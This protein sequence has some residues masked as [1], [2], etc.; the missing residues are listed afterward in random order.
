[1]KNI[2]HSASL[3][4]SPQR[5]HPAG[6]RS[7]LALALLCAWG[8]AA[9]ADEAATQI[10]VTGSVV[11][12]R[13]D[14]VPYAA[15]VVGQDALRTAGPMINL[16]E[17]LA[18]VPGLVVNLRNNYAQDLQ[19]SSRGFGSRAGFGVRGLRLYADGIPAT[20]PDGQGQVSHFDLAGAERV[21][22]LR[23]PFSTL[24]GSSSG[25]VISVF[26][27]PVRRAEGEAALD[28]G[29]DGLRQL[30]AGVALP[31]EGGFDL[32]L[33]ASAMRVDGFRP[34]SSAE[35]QAAN[36]RL[37]WQ[38]QSDRVV[39]RL[40]SLNQPAQD[41]LGLDRSQFDADP[42]QTTQQA[43]DYD[44]RKN[45]RQ[46][47]AGASWLH[48]FADL[49][50][51]QDSQLAVY[52]GSRSVTQWQA[53]PP[54]SQSNARHG[55]GVVDFDRD[56]SGAEAKLRWAWD[57]L[58]L[59]AGLALDDQ[60]DQRR[61]Y[62]NFTGTGS[63]QVLGVTG[64]LRRNEENRARSTDAFAQADWAFSTDWTASAGVRSG[65]AKLSTADEFLS[66]G[67]DSGSRSYRYTNPVLGLR[68]QAWHQGDSSLQW[69]AAAA[70]GTETPTLGEL[71]YRADGSGGFSS[72]LKPQTSR[73]TELGARW[74]S[75]GLWL[76]ATLFQARVADEISVLS[77]SKGRSSYQNVGRT[78]RQGLELAGRWSFAPDWQAQWAATQLDATYRDAF[79]TCSGTPCAS[80]NTPVAAGN[81]LPGTAR[82]SGWAGLAW[83]GGRWGEI[84]LEGHG[85]GSTPVNDLN[86][87]FAPSYVTYS[88]RWLKA[89]P[90]GQGR[91][92]ELLAR[93]DNLMD[94]RYAGSVI[95][96]DS[97]GRY[98]E[99][100]APRSGLLSLRLLGAL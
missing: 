43:M 58:D 62:E 32:K 94:R 54:S 56:F 31:L 35:R 47:Q 59:Q 38:D 100:G 67:D 42:Y 98:F 29:S 4:S 11:Q 95:V 18:Q 30:R 8:S 1:M 3:I 55:G 14:D 51:L 77:N 39:L 49:G 25:G 57:G 7:V 91:T 61:G 50:A 84:G 19:I 72:D 52:A 71:A 2:L 68:W 5:S 80:A 89:Y 46:L 78:L 45:Q 88:L 34:H 40:N 17:A 9:V 70:R 27:A 92:L 60:R 26:S 82:R 20:G 12:H 21:E 65:Q 74:R 37:G 69:H 63:S 76:D 53:I 48:R 96:N 22:V 93:V 99:T 28:L 6:G 64:A 75:S 16:S 97:N 41:P 85:V 79:L 24:Y 33:G 13:L 44:T 10:V 66:N 23:G 73:Q 15:S 81:R 86:T 83:Q 36:A 90:L 87:D